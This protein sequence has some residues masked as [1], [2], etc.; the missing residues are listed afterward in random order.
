MLLHSRHRWSHLPSRL[1]PLGSLARALLASWWSPWVQVN[2][3]VAL[4]A[5]YWTTLFVVFTLLSYFCAYLFMLVYMWIVVAGDQFD[6]AQYGVIY[7]IA[8]DANLWL[9][10]VQNAGSNPTL[11]RRYR[12]S[13]EQITPRRVL[14]W[15]SVPYRSCQPSWGSA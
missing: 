14:R 8:A 15:L 3:E 2:V 1:N 4:T 11:R 10:Q 9:L 13:P 5:R 7:R 6:P 12:S